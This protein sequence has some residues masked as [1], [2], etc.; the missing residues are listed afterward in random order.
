MG[1]IIN[2]ALA[3][4][5][6]MFFLGAVIGTD[7]SRTFDSQVKADAQIEKEYA[8]QISKSFIPRTPGTDWYEQ[9]VIDWQNSAYMFSW[10]LISWGK[11]IGYKNPMQAYAYLSIVPLI[12]AFGAEFLYLIQ[13]SIAMVW[14]GWDKVREVLKGSEVGI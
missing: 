12:L 4:F 6:T 7:Y 9:S 8:E 10:T 1:K 14:V 3:L 13:Y 5:A 2:L 11:Q